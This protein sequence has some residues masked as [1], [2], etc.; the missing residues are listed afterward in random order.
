MGHLEACAAAAGLTSLLLT[1]LSCAALVAP[2][3]QLRR[4]NA[5][6]ASHIEG[7]PFRMPVEVVGWATR[8]PLDPSGDDCA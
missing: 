1:P 3:A 7:K 4:L 6:I 2:N 5:H 8:Q